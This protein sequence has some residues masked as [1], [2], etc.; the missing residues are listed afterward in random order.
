[1]KYL[2][3]QIILFCLFLSSAV[4]QSYHIK[5]RVVAEN[6][7][8]IPFANISLHLSDSTLVKG[9]SSDSNGNFTI[10]KVK[11]DNYYLLISCIGFDSYYAHFEGI[12]SNIRLG[13]LVLKEQKVALKNVTVT[14]A[15]IIDKPNRKIVFPSGKQ[16]E[17]STNG[18]NLL[19]NVMLSG[20]KVNSL[21]NSISLI[22]GSEIQLRINGVQVSEKEVIALQPEDIKQIEYM[23]NPGLRYGNAKAVLNYKTKRYQTGGGVSL[24]LMQSPHVLFSEDQVS[25][26]L[27]VNKSEFKLNYS[28]SLRDF[29]D[30]WRTNEEKFLFKDGSL[31][32]RKEDGEPGRYTN[33]IHNLSLTYNYQE[34]EKYFFNMNVR[35][36]GNLEPHNDYRSLLSRSDN[37]AYQVNVSDYTDTR[38]YFPSIDL[39]YLRHINKRERILFNL[40]GTYIGTDLKGS[41]SEKSKGKTNII[42]RDIEGKKYSL[43]AEGLYEKDFNS[44]KLTVGCKHTQS[45]TENTYGGTNSYNTDLDQSDTYM[46][47][48]YAGNKNKLNYSFGIGINRSWLKQ[49]KDKG[50]E[51]YN[52]RPRFNVNYKF[53][54]HFS[55]RI[56]GKMDT[57]SP[58]LSKLSDV[59]QA[60]DLLQIQRGNPNLDPYQQYQADLYLEYHKGLFT[61][62]AKSQYIVAQDPIM[63]TTL[64]ENNKFIRT[65][66]NQQKWT[67]YNYEVTGRVGMLWK[68]LQVSATGGLNRYISEGKDYLHTYNNFYYR[69]EMMFVHKSWLLLLNANNNWDHFWGES[70][71]GGE[72]MHMIMV[73]KNHKNYS[74]GVGVINPF[75]DNYKRTNEDRNQYAWNK[76]QAFVNESSKMFVVKLAWNFNFGKNYSRGRK[77]LNNADNDSGIM[78]VIK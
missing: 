77:R 43:I 41:Y 20:V 42:N 33:Q 54:E 4:A 18:L 75:T 6:N 37:S 15:N 52:I 7:E 34:P 76:R 56:T 29:Y 35:Y 11:S 3:L 10:S 74:I 23:D 16:K 12:S 9:V 39:Y 44:G 53:S 55:G 65:Y 36:V 45:K 21:M 51:T 57:Y 17:A 60:I 14:A 38:S 63:E 26:R 13:N 27:N 72:N 22:D 62:I 5:G 28:L 69:A 50:Y 2:A 25:A 66:N 78:N 46:Y 73:M 31:L 70:V 30:Y 64:R 47:T 58:D 71:I 67:K 68:V 32:N 59:E 1:M 48:E 40:V 24:D 61:G 49:N 19:Q 8:A